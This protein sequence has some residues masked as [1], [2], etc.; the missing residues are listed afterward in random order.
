MESSTYTSRSRQLDHQFYRFHLHLLAVP[1]PSNNPSTPVYASAEARVW[2]LVVPM[3]IW[4]NKL[5][6]I[7]KA[8]RIA[9]RMDPSQI[10]WNNRAGATK[11]TTA[12]GT[13]SQSLTRSTLEREK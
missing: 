13:A 10:K 11:N 2:F 9:R 1:L 4:T 6:P 8:S 5:R 12:S 3:K 7:M